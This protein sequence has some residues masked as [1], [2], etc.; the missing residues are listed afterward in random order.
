MK[1]ENRFNYAQKGIR[2]AI[3]VSV[4]ML[5]SGCIEMFQYVGQDDDGR[6][7]TTFS[8]RIQKAILEMASGFSGQGAIDY[9]ELLRFTEQDITE[10]YSNGSEM[11]IELIDTDLEYGFRFTVAVNS[12]L[13]IEQEELPMFPRFEKGVTTISFDDF[14][15]DG[16]TDP[17]AMAFLSSSKYRLI[18]SK[19]HV[20]TISSAWYEVGDVTFPVEHHDLHSVF[21]IEFPIIY[22]MGLAREG[23]LRI[24]H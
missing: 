21:Y 6:L 19:T 15:N 16:E 3:L 18:I 20:P 2:V 13:Q 5:L 14:D 9:G 4:G 11:R 7:H 22:I 1:P 8:V 10:M 17:M 12:D 24:R 23:K